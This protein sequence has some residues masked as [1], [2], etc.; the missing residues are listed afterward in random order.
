MNVTQPNADLYIPDGVPEG[1]AL[2]RTT[3]LGIGAHQ[4]DL[5]FMAFHG[6]LSCYQSENQWFGGITCTDGAGSVRSGPFADYTDEQMKEERRREQRRAAEIGHYG[7][8]IQL[9]LPSSRIKDPN[10]P[11][12]AQDLISLLQTTRPQVIYTHNL[13]DKHAS[14]VAVVVAVLQAIRSLPPKER[15]EQLLGCEVWRGLDWMQ[16][17]EKVA[18]DVSGHLELAKQLNAVF[19]SQIAGGK[20]FDLATIGRRRANATFF[21]S[22]QVDTSDQVWFAMDLTPL[23]QDDPPDIKDFI[24]GYIDRFATEVKHTL[25]AH[26]PEN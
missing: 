26:L 8:I 7:S 15:P 16:D 9:D 20:R 22:H 10:D 14:H 13:A 21:Q 24:A 3:H 25:A 11:S 12:L 23:I 17:G 5:E 6:I 19:A 4:D 1:Q 2:A 18:L